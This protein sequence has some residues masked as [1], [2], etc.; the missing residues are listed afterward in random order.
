MHFQDKHMKL[1]L[2]YFLL[3]DGTESSVKKLFIINFFFNS[4]KHDKKGNTL[5]YSD[6]A[7]MFLSLF[8]YF[9]LG[10]GLIF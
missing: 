5:V 7:S 4:H 3:R 2:F 1:L 8:G 6:K 10:G 9:F